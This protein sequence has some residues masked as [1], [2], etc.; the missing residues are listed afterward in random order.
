MI[1]WPFYL[2]GLALHYLIKY[3]SLAILLSATSAGLFAWRS[4]RHQAYTTRL[5]ETFTVLNRDNWD[6]DVIRARQVLTEIKEELRNTPGLIAR[7]AHTSNATL[8]TFRKPSTL[9]RARVRPGRKLRVNPSLKK[10]FRMLVKH[11]I[12]P[13]FIARRATLQTVMND[14]ENLALGVKHGIIDEPFLY[15]YMRSTI[16]NDW[17][18][19]GPLVS[20][21]RRVNSNQQLY[22]EFE[23]LASDWQRERSYRNN[24]FKLN[25]SRR[26]LRI[27]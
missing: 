18:F 24:R 16:L 26:W 11:H 2:I 23:G 14:Y 15:Q 1:I 25:K 5:R 9:K 19:L 21:F 17:Y 8:G 10:G 22:V 3:S 20:E 6:E 13:V 12:D 4:M 7:Y 27:K